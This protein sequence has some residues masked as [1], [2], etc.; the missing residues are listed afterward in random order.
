MLWKARGCFRF[1]TPDWEVS[2]VRK[3][4]PA[5]CDPSDSPMLHVYRDASIALILDQRRRPNRVFDLINSV[6]RYGPSAAR[7]TEIL[8]AWGSVCRH[9]PV[10]PLTKVC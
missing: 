8:R 10:R 9:E 7:S 3:F 5:A 2:R 6:M 1:S 4:R